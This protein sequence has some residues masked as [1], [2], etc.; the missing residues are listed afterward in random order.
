[1]Q[2]L[3]VCHLLGKICCVSEAPPTM[4]DLPVW[5]WKREAALYQN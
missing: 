4:D 1:M 5:E 2:T 3:D